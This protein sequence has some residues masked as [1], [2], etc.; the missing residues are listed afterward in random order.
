MSYHSSTIEDLIS[1]MTRHTIHYPMD[2]SSIGR[3]KRLVGICKDLQC[4][5]LMEQV[6]VR[7][8][9]LLTHPKP[10][11]F[12][13]FILSA[14]A[15]RD[16]Y[17]CRL[18]LPSAARSLWANPAPADRAP[19]ENGLPGWSKLDI[20]AMPESLLEALP[21]K[22]IMALGR[23]YRLRGRESKGSDGDWEKVAAEFYRL[24]TE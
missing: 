15:L 20:T 1:L 5:Y 9:E 4:P 16:P 13:I 19:S 23:A 14:L 7:I 21:S 18:A 17:I 6:T 10:R 12:D 8:K 22:H 11:A 3:I 24:M 2:G